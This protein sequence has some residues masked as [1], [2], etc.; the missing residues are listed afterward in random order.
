[1]STYQTSRAGPSLVT[2]ANTGQSKMGMYGTLLAAANYHD[3]CAIGEWRRVGFTGF[4]G[5]CLLSANGSESGAADESI[6]TGQG[7]HTGRRGGSC[8]IAAPRRN[9]LGFYFSLA[10]I[11]EITRSPRRDR[12]GVQASACPPPVH[13]GAWA[14]AATSQAKARTPTPAHL[15][16]VPQF[17]GGF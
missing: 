4:L 13:S 3:D 5:L 17:F 10:E 2:S 12:F 1:M 11:A 6:R 7:Q 16:R 9:G 8:R 14:S 15:G